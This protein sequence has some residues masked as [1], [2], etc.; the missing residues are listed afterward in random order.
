M[1]AGGSA[2]A[3]LI[4]LLFSFLLARQYSTADIALFG[5]FM[6][7]ASPLSVI[8]CLRFEYALVIPENEE[9]A[10][11]L[12]RAGV[13]S[14]LLFSALSVIALVVSLLFSLGTDSI[15][16]C[17]GLV[18]YCITGALSQS[19]LFWYQ[20]NK[21]FKKITW[22]R[23]A[24]VS[25][26]AIISACLG[27]L[28]MPYGLVF[29]YLSGSLIVYILLILSSDLPHVNYLKRPSGTV[30]YKYREF[31][32]FNLLP[33]LLNALT[34]S[35]PIFV[36]NLK[37]SPTDAGNFVLARQ[38]LLAF[39]GTGA[40]VLS[41]WYFQRSAEIAKNN[42]AQLPEF[43]RVFFTGFFPS[44]V[45][46]FV[47]FFFGK[48]LFGFLYGSQWYQAGE[49]SWILAVSVVCH[50][51][52]YPLMNALGVIGKIKYTSLWQLVYF[53]LTACL[54]VLPAM[55]TSEFVWIIA[56]I[57]SICYVLLLVLVYRLLR[58]NDMR[59]SR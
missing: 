10:S 56:G 1:L 32:L 54:C 6:A 59:L 42:S 26:V 44:L 15:V 36:V 18:I 14:G 31:P 4:P 19:A 51:S 37:F 12:F 29:G 47:L 58:V 39:S 40:V 13:L 3:Q 30:L 49:L 43:F 27:F 28:A 52:V 24:Q 20:R 55:K 16:I 35:V 57:D 17:T 22:L 53:L 2:F 5:T 46:L 11:T 21:Q 33:A 7:I 23:I 50:V 48:D 41:Q 45:L 34:V 38:I 9:E 8:F 25:V